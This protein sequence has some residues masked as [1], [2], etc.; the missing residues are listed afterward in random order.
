MLAGLHVRR[1]RGVCVAVLIIP[2]M[3]TIVRSHGCRSAS[4]R[5]S[6]FLERLALGIFNFLVGRRG[7]DVE[8][9]L[10]IQPRI[11]P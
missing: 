9:S 3:G 6:V 8:H 2:F 4:R 11:S 5:L 7:V 1:G 10:N